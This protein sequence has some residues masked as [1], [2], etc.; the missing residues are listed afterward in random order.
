MIYLLSEHLWA[1]AMCLAL[2][3]VWK[4]SWWASYIE[5]FVFYPEGSGK[6]WKGFRLESKLLT[7]AF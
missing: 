2:C 4:T 7:S 5:D 1:C 3:W 6:S